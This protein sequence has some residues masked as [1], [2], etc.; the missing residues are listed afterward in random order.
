MPATYVCQ[1]HVAIWCFVLNLIRHGIYCLLWYLGKKLAYEC[2]YRCCEV[3]LIC[4]WEQLGPRAA[5]CLAPLCLHNPVWLVLQCAKITKATNP[6][7]LPNSSAWNMNYHGWTAR[8]P[9][10]LAGQRLVLVRCFQRG[11]TCFDPFIL[12]T[13][14]HLNHYA[15]SWVSTITILIL[16]HIVTPRHLPYN[17]SNPQGISRVGQPM[18]VTHS[19][20]CGLP[21]VW[22]QIV[23]FP[24][25][26][27]HSMGYWHLRLSDICLLHHQ[28]NLR[29]LSPLT[30]W[31]WAFYQ[32]DMT[33]KV[34]GVF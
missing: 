34:S 29:I 1:H 26:T 8:S 32:G 18:Q 3:G 5:V 4:L 15:P 30:V 20:R 7:P 28:S 9:G 23:K 2:L 25:A 31:R 17:T 16:Q 10:Q 11:D 19:H 12:F 6:F 24:P 21:W 27:I 13:C 14:P 22:A 33:Q